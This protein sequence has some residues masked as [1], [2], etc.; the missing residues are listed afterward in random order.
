MDR[1][2]PL[3]VLS[4]VYAEI[5]QSESGAVPVPGEWYSEVYYCI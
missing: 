3:Q 1:K 2:K 4:E 5:N